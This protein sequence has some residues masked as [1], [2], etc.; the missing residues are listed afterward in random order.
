VIR[1][2]RRHR[3]P[4]PFWLAAVALT[5]LTVSTVARVTGTAAAERARWGEQRPVVV[6]RH[7]LRPGERLRD[8]DVRMVPAALVPRGAVAAPGGQVVAAW[9]AGGEIVVRDRLAPRG[10]SATAALLPPGSRGVAVPAGQA[11]LPVEVGDRVDVVATDDTSAT[12]IARDAVVI[13][14]DEAAVTVAVDREDAASV[15]YAV[16]AAAVTLV[17]TGA[18]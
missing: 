16:T 7:D 3:R 13:A 8:V 2:R 15:A 10:L 9:I 17:L 5:A 12:T 4:A 11:P 6:A 14:V 18:R 1:R